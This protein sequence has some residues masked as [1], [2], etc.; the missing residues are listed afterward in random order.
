MVHE[1]TQNMYLLAHQKGK[2]ILQ[3]SFT[4]NHELKLLHRLHE[5][6]STEPITIQNI[7]HLRYT[8]VHSPILHNM[9][10]KFTT[11]I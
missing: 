7:D 11:I 9:S 2:M 1:Y 10:T 5:I 6:F 8:G 4:A 3:L